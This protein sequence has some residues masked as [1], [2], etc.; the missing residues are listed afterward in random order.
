MPFGK[1][2]SHTL[3]AVLVSATWI[4]APVG[5]ALAQHHDPMPDVTAQNFGEVHF[6]ISC[7][8]ET[9]AQFERAVAMLHSFFW[10]ATVKAFT[11]LTES[12]P[13]CAMAWWGLAISQR[14]NPLVP[15]FPT[16]ALRRGW[17]AIQRA[18]TVPSQ[19]QRERDWIAAL[20]NFF[21]DYDKVDQHTRTLAYEAAMARLAE[22]YPDDA[23]A[24]IFYALALNEAVD[25]SDKT[26]ARQLKAAAILERLEPRMPNHPGIA[27]YLIHSYDYPPLAERGLPAAR[28]Y[29][30]VAPSAPHAVHMPSHIFS[31]L[32]LWQEAIPC[33]L[34]A[35]TLNVEYFSKTDPRFAA[36]PALIPRRYH[37]I[38]FLVNAYMQ[39]AQ[40][41]KASRLLEQFRPITEPVPMF[42]S[43]HTG[44]AAAF[45]RFDFDRSAWAEAAALPILITPYPQAE[46]IN[47]FGRAIGAAR[48]G[49][50]VKAKSEIEQLRLITGKL[51]EVQDTYWAEQVEIQ[52][53]AASAWV[54]LAEGRRDDAVR[55][56]RQ[57]ADLEDR[58]EKHI[59]ME[60]RLSPM[61]EM[62]GEMLLETR[63]PKAALDAFNV[64]LKNAPNR[65]RSI[66]GAAKAAESAGDREGAKQWNQR[67]L[68]LTKDAD[69]ER[70]E[71]AAARRFLASD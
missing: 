6:P 20:G 62:L 19:T 68:D 36:N 59:A 17:E 12:D 41:Q 16:E 54:A 45:V 40:D 43:M 21:R 39:T 31:T 15:P 58:T 4:A 61:R 2:I 57:A 22:K 48:S 8:K 7:R 27:H 64:S 13:Y 29:A 1:T 42:Y 56:M 60:N 24:Q 11:A 25:L 34:A 70:P 65:Y 67:L 49:D 44:F 50:V 53:I 30:A 38:D 33:D 55:L 37:S 47:R 10:P 66:A 14:P 18:Q 9:Q 71:M 5:P 51:A 35:D 28:H 23:E 32:G 3:R 63:D 69:T 46:A 52:E 26:Y